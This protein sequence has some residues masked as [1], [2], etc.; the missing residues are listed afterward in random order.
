MAAEPDIR[1]AVTYSFGQNNPMIRSQYHLRPSKEGLLAWNIR[2][3]IALSAGLQVKPIALSRID[4]VDENYWYAFEGQLP[5]CRSILEHFRLIE[6]TDPGYPIILDA[7]GR[8]MDGMHRVCKAICRGDM[9]IPAVQFAE[10][11]EPDYVG[12]RPEDFP[13]D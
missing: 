5:T 13:Y 4:E 3:L 2:R 6:E 8:L 10:T 7:D 12:R 11:P 1:I 9:H